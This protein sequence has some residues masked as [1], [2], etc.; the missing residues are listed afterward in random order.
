MWSEGKRSW[1][2]ANMR[3]I[4]LTDYAT[5][6]KDGKIPNLHPDRHNFPTKGKTV[7]QRMENWTKLCRKAGKDLTAT[8]TAGRYVVEW[9]ESQEHSRWMQAEFDK[10]GACC[11]PAGWATNRSR[12]RRTWRYEPGT[13]T[14]T[15]CTS[16]ALFVQNEET[17]R[18]QLEGDTAT[19]LEFWAMVRTELATGR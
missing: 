13:V 6:Y 2:G 16:R 18:E 14:L 1:W 3:S 11:K 9:E 7:K 12:R 8:Y 17:E 4:E 5:T 19:A 10:H 15:N